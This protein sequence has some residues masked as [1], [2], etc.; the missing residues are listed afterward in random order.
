M[1]VDFDNSKKNLTTSSK[2]FDYL[3]KENKGKPD[4]EKEHLFDQNRDDI[5]PEEAT[6][7]IDGNIAKLGKADEKY[8]SFHISPSAKEIA[9]INGDVVKV[10]E[11]VR[12]VM[13]EYAKN[14]NKGLT[15]DDIVY[16]AKVERTRS[17]KNKDIEVSQGSAAAGENKF[18]DQLHVHVVVSRKDKTNK[19][20]LSPKDNARGGTNFK[21]PGQEQTI[22]RGFDRN[23]FRNTAEHLFD[24]KFGFQRSME[25]SFEFRRLKEHHPEEFKKVY[26]ISK[27]NYVPITDLSTEFAK[28]EYTERHVN[29]ILSSGVKKREA[30]QYLKQ[31]GISFSDKGPKL[32]GKTIPFKSLNFSKEAGDLI[33]SYYLTKQLGKNVEGKGEEEDKER[34]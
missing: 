7:T 21:V 12:E 11:F 28:K 3:D 1:I 5:T 31:R 20:K 13:D 8:Y 30:D 34:D 15:G 33:K 16:F 22:T 17:F 29:K 23:A 2:I 14:F 4:A 9:A 32:V 6:K 27:T 24:K 19:I 26:G 25:D 10:K 18:G